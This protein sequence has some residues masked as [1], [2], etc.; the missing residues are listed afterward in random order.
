MAQDVT[1]APGQVLGAGAQRA[2]LLYRSFKTIQR[3]GMEL[4]QLQGKIKFTYWTIVALSLFMFLLGI[5]LLFVPLL[6]AAGG[7]MD[8]VEALAAGGFGLSNL[9]GLFFLKPIDRIHDLV[10]DTS[11]ITLAL[12]SFHIQ[13][14]L[15]MME[16]G[17]L[18]EDPKDP[19][20]L[21]TETIEKVA[22][23]IGAAAEKSII[24]VQKY[25]ENKPE[26][27][28]PPSP[29]ITSV[30]PNEGKQGESLP[31]TISGTSFTGATAVG[32]GAGVAVSFQV[33][34]DTKITAKITIDAA[35][36]LGTRDV[37]VAIPGVEVERKASFTVKAK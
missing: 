23:G 13:S 18:D 29:T 36:T 4:G 37:S 33:D 34:S 7:H 19:K 9:V 2:L 27:E 11:Q 22:K 10:G 31:V 17:K 30:S 12:N 28:T 1:K 14:S 32:F 16:I 8:R 35:A 21:D 5:G 6:A 25:F 20:H 26:S 15:L 3:N 24:L